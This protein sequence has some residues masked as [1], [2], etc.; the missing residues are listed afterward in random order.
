LIPEE[1]FSDAMMPKDE[2]QFR[3]QKQYRDN[4]RI[5]SQSKGK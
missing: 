2:E 1:D 5:C 3:M 4:M